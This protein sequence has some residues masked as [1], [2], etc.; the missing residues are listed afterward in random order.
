M[1]ILSLLICVEKT[2]HRLLQ[3]FFHTLMRQDGNNHTNIDVGVILLSVISYSFFMSA[4]CP[5]LKRLTEFIVDMI[6]MLPPIVKFRIFLTK[7]RMSG[8]KSLSNRFVR[9]RSLR[10]KALEGK[11]DFLLKLVNIHRE[12]WEATFS[13]GAVMSRLSFSCL[14]L[15]FVDTCMIGGQAIS[16]RLFDIIHHSSSAFISETAGLIFLLFTALIAAPWII[17]SFLIDPDD[18]EWIEY[19]PLAREIAQERENR[20]R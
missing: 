3:L 1:Q 18:A 19:P 4:I 5:A 17:H 20:M 10:D 12:R 7:E 2:S 13:A 6:S 16:R 9:V 8:W 14:V 15:L 11:D